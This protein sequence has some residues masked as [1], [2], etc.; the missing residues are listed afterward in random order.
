M[1][2]D[3]FVL[4]RAEARELDRQA[5]E[6]HGVPSL[7]LMENAGRACAFELM[8]ELGGDPEPVL[9][10]VGPGNNGGDGL[11]IARTLV[12]HGLAARVVFV[13]S[14]EQLESG[15]SDFAT[16][17]AL[18]RD[19]NEPIEVVSDPADLR[20]FGRGTGWV[21][22]ALFGTGLTRPLEGLYAAVVE[23]VAGLGCPVLAVDMPSG[24]DAD[25]GRVLGV[26][27]PARLTVTFV[28]S[29]PGLEK[30]DGPALAGRVVVVE[31]G[32]PRP[33]VLAAARR[34]QNDG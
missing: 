11:V 2:T 12:N 32:V 20:A 6:E 4:T 33:L 30:A 24:L 27:L 18:W 17:L 14:S 26:A 8:R 5:I 7:L 29:K 22:D 3:D 10:L 21:V 15:S 16:N 28:A 23:A 31:I 34:S 1:P 19:L 13:G 9:V 25:E